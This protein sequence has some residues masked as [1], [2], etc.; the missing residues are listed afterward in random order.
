MSSLLCSACS[1]WY[2]VGSELRLDQGDRGAV[3][4]DKDE[5]RAFSL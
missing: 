3:E 1:L 5:V 4:V 2:L